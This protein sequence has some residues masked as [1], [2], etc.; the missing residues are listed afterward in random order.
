MD[1]L[2]PD[3]R[4]FLDAARQADEPSPAERARGDEA[5]RAALA[6]RGIEGLP[7]LANAGA[8]TGHVRGSFAQRGLLA[9]KL[10][11]G[12]VALVVASYVGARLLRPGIESAPRV[13]SREAQVPAPEASP[14]MAA[15]SIRASEL[16]PRSA[17]ALEESRAHVHRAPASLTHRAELRRTLRSTDRALD[18]SLEGELRT[19]ASVDALVRER[20]FGD[21]LQL[22]ERTETEAAAV[23][24]E[25]RAA[26]R[27]LARCGLDPNARVLRERD[28]FL[29]ASPRS[30]LADRVRNACGQ[31]ATAVE[32]P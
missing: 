28:Q 25:E 18:S 32:E 10:G 31:V 21:A 7:L 11:T 2:P 27:I 14:P 13:P 1:K 12:A 8:S 29:R 19:V 23:L 22:L 30:V 3:A 4:A 26:L 24:R 6:R 16:E 15:P 20:R 17:P 9:V 5:V